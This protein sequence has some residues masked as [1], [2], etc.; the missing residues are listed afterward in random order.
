MS[1]QLISSYR[2][3]GDHVLSVSSCQSVLAIMVAS[4]GLSMFFIICIGLCLYEYD[5][6]DQS[7]S[8]CLQTSMRTCYSMKRTAF[9]GTLSLSRKFY[10]LYDLKSRAL[11]WIFFVVC[12]VFAVTYLVN[13]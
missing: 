2:C 11:V 8:Y 10:I 6:D 7:Y 13:R 5:T 12:S 1:F 4:Y 9:P 3:S